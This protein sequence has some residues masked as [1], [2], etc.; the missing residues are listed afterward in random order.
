MKFKPYEQQQTTLLPPSIEDLISESHIVRVIDTIVEELDY[1]RLYSSYS[2]EGQP[3][4][5]PKMLLK[6]LIYGYS[7]GIR[8]SRK[9]AEKLHSDVTFMFLSGMQRPDFR[10][11]SDF[12]LNKRDYLEEYFIQILQ[13]CKQAGLYK[14]NHVSIDGSKIKANASKKK[15]QDEEDLLRN[16]KAVK[17]ILEEAEAIDKEE[18]EKYGKDN[19]GYDLPPELSTKEKLLKKIK[20]AKKK[21]DK[22]K[23]KRINLTDHDASF[24]R[25]ADGGIDVC[26]NAQL[27]VD[28]ENQIIITCDVS[29]KG[30]D[31]H[32]FAEVYEKLR[33]MTY[34]SPNE[35]T[36]DAGYYSGATYLY[37]EKNKIDAYIP[38]SRH[39]KE[40]KEAI[41]KFSRINFQYDKENDVYICPEGKKMV[42]A[43][44][45]S[46]NKVK[47]RIYKGTSCGDCN[48]KKVCI[49]KQNAPLRQIQIYENDY[50]KEYMRQKLR[51][52]IGK[53]K[54]RQRKA[55]VEPVFAQLKYIMGFERF[56][57]RGIDKVRAEFTLLCTAYNIKKIYK[58]L[59]C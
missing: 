14:L 41:G 58:L 52:K 29:K 56:L 36:A 25:K 12:R 31:N 30:N 33:G 19:N 49:S 17:K 38:E 4:Y 20:E 57:L 46:R 1:E 44:N 8:S 24:M 3:A 13:I 18:D 40:S 35:V 2:E 43:K 10:T 51:S 22:D 15:T 32:L 53:E 42:F 37:L 23:L 39:R 26:Y 59:P 16:E 54:L 55:I 50:Y 7:I 28:S 48:S 11:I 9:I 6:L 34:Q 27:A 21:L 5:H 45:S 47:F